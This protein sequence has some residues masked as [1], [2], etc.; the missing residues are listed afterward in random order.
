LNI[1]HFRDTNLNIVQ[2]NLEEAT[3]QTIISQTTHTFIDDAVALWVGAKRVTLGLTI[4]ALTALAR[5][6]TAPVDRLARA[7]DVGGVIESRRIARQA[8]A[9]AR[10]RQRSYRRGRFDVFGIMAA[11]RNLRDLT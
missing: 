1:V 7:C 3:M 10:A 11:F 9:E 8:R 2:I 6:L 5:T 4:D